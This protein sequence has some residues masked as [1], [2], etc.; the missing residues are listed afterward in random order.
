MAKQTTL[1]LAAA[2][3]CAGWLSFAISAPARADTC[4]WGG[5]ESQS[6]RCFDCM[7]RVWTPYGWKLVNTCPPRYTNDFQQH[8]WR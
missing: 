7:R 1:I 8:D 6:I 5:D 2:A 4:R 3:A